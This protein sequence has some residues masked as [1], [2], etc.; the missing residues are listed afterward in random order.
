MLCVTFCSLGFVTSV[1]LWN[2][3]FCR[4][5][6]YNHF[7]SPIRLS[8]SAVETLFSQYKHSSGDKLSTSNYAIARASHLIKHTVSTHH[9]SKRYRDNALDLPDCVLQ[10]KKYGQ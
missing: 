3:K 7:I 8:G 4:V 5:V 9:S 10:K 2:D 6:S 1:C